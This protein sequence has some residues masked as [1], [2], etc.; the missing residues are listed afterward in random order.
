MFQWQRLIA[1]ETAGT[2]STDTTE[3]EVGNV[4]VPGWA[5]SVL[6]AKGLYHGTVMTTTEDL[7]G[8]FRLV[9]DE[10]TIDPLNFP[11]PPAGGL[12]GAASS[13]ITL[14]VTVPAFFDVTP[15]DTLRMYAAFDSAMTVND[16][17]D[18]YVCFSNKS[19]PM[20]MH[21]QKTA[22][23]A[24]TDT[25]AGSAEVTIS[26]IAGK[27]REILGI[28]G[29]V[30]AGS[31][32]TVSESLCGHLVLKSV[33]LGWVD[34][35]L[36]IGNITGSLGA[37]TNFLNMPF[38]YATKGLLEDFDGFAKSVWPDPFPLTGKED[39]TVKYYN[40]R[41]IGNNIDPSWRM[42]LIW[43]E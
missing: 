37:D 10:N 42:F 22:F 6:Y 9:N 13:L 41:D 11:L 4:K 29:Y 27:T 12:A 7:G 17:F 43:R 19:A 8:Y 15:N 36:N 25:L 20:K 35:D 39:F 3:V 21:I 16:I 24:G 28:I 40:D 23:S 1:D 18:G 2:T 30:T 33:A 32:F 5:R 38:V 31:A 34:Q 14:P 26:T